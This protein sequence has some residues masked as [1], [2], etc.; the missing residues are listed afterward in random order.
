MTAACL[1]IMT[2]ACESSGHVLDLRLTPLT[3]RPEDPDTT[4]IYDQNDLMATASANGEFVLFTSR[5]SGTF[6]QYVMNVDG[7]NVHVLTSGPGTQ[8]QGSWSPDGEKIV[9]VQREKKSQSL[10]VMDFDGSEPKILV[11]DL[12]SWPTPF[13]AP[14]GRHIVY[15]ADGPIG[16]WDIWSVDAETG[17]REVLFGSP[18][19]DMQPAISPDGSRVVF[20]SRRDGEDEEIYVAD[21]N[22]GPWTQLTNN[23][24]S[25]YTPTWSPDGSRIVFQSPRGGRWTILTIKPDGSDETPVTVYPA[26]YDPVWSHDGREIFF[27]SDRDG[28]RGI[29]VMNADGLNQ[30]KLTNTEPSTF[31]R[32]VRDAGVDEAARVFREAHAA[33][34]DAVFF[35]EEEVRYLGQNYLEIGHVRQATVLFEVNVEAFPQSSAAY[36]DLGTAH[37]AAGEIVLAIE[38]YQRANELDPEDARV[39]RLLADLR[40]RREVHAGTN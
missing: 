1:P 37:L 12:G 22:G 4:A 18:A 20:I 39:A 32:V 2:A 33:D 3:A 10:A 19:A 16:S 24:V 9:Y 27:N 35:Y 17:E 5:R 26:Q 14:D 8:M 36:A 31:V 38:S 7:S 29:Y 40:A 11:N 34:P 23:N 28:R 25:D 30:R 21:L 13:F 15:H 6:R